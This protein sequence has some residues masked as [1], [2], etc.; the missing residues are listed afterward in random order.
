MESGTTYLCAIQYET[1]RETLVLTQN[2]IKGGGGGG[3]MGLLA[4][5]TIFVEKNYLPST[6]AAFWA[7]LAGFQIDSVGH[8]VL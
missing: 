3:I 2:Y 1:R 8:N 5:T 6:L 4:V 7:P